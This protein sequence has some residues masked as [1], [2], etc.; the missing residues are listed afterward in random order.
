MNASDMGGEVMP[1]DAGEG[2]FRTSSFCASG[3]C[4]EVA[5]LADGSIAVR[6]SKDRGRPAHIF[7]STEW[8][9]FVAGVKHGEFDF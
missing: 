4:V 3:G 9:D 2:L 1:T 7:T 6:D 5:H 8:R